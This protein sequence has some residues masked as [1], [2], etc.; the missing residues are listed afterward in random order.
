MAPRPRASGKR[1]HVAFMSRGQ[2]RT[3]CKSLILLDR[4]L[5]QMQHAIALSRS[6][7]RIYFNVLRPMI[8]LNHGG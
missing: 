7:I 2:I 8:G 1:T 3:D 4:D 5:R 6:L